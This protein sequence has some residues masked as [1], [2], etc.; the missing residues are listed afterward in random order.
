MCIGI[1]LELI[2]VQGCHRQN[3]CLDC[4][5]NCATN[6]SNTKNLYL[7]QS[8]EK[9]LVFSRG[10]SISSTREKDEVVQERIERTVCLYLL[11]MMH[12]P[13]DIRM[14]HWIFIP[15]SKTCKSNLTIK[16]EKFVLPL[17]NW[18]WITPWLKNRTTTPSNSRKLDKLTPLTISKWFL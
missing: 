5:Y 6:N 18:I 15:R 17:W 13:L 10:T 7:V 8:S 11:K 9:L 14:G 4:Q 2:L 16:R 3:G 12:G 1:Y